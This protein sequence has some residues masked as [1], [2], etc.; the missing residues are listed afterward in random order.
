MVGELT[1][2]G[3][4]PRAGGEVLTDAMKR[5]PF[6]PTAGSSNGQC[7]HSPHPAN[8]GDPQHM[9]DD[10]QVAAHTF[11]EFVGMLED[12][13]LA[14]DLTDE[15]KKINEEMHDFAQAS[16]KKAKASLTIKID[17][18]LDRGI[19]EIASK[20]STKLPELERDRSVC[21][22]TPDGH[23]SPENPKQLKLFGEVRDVTSNTEVRT[24]G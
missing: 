24:V 16:G 10:R 19:F 22:S 5:R 2:K 23:F 14:S 18:V 12:G 11:S 9:P 15:L 20:L 21:W 1:R 17:F 4:P 8:T 3:I 7:R 6:H 13:R